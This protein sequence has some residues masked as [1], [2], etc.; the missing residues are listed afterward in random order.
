GAQNQ[1][2]KA[3]FDTGTP[4]VVFLINGRPL[5]INWV[6]ANV[7][8]ILEGWYLGAEGGTAA[9]EVLFGDINPGGKLPITFPRSVGQLPDF[10]DHKP[11][12]N[13]SYAFVDNS[14]LFPFGYG[15]SYT[16]FRFDN[17]RVT[18]AKMKSGDTA[19]VTID[20]TNT[21]S[22]EGDEVAELYIH[23]QLSTVTQPV[24]ALRGFKRVSLQPGQETTVEFKLAPDALSIYDENMKRVVQPGVFDIMAGPSS[25]ETKT[26]E[27]EVIQQ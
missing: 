9:A 4:T 14:P 25:V 8:A 1:L 15:L 21:G 13:R 16:T 19:T 11:S 2:V 10:Y 20:V 7:P 18:P 23:Q 26:A 5:S 12:R 24:M 3:V 17:F 22:R 6:A 27:L